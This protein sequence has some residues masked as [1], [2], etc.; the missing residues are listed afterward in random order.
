M[1]LT[2]DKASAG[3]RLDA[4]IAANSD[5]SRSLAARLIEAGDVTVGGKAKD[6][7]YKIVL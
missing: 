7:K 1:I 5:I 6:K 2:A 4:Y 3:T